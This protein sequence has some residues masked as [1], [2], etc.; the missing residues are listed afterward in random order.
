MR[1]SGRAHDCDISDVASSISTRVPQFRAM[2]PAA[3][4]VAC[5]ATH[6]GS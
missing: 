5:A 3:S 2:A 6:C 4:S 1:P